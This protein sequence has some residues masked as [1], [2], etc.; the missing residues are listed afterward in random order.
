MLI[1]IRNRYTDEIL[2]ST[3]AKDLRGADLVG[4]YLRGA[5]LRDANLGGADLGGAYLRDADLRGAD[6]R[7]ANLRDADLGGADLRDAKGIDPRSVNPLLSLFL[8]PGPVRSFKLVNSFGQGPYRGGITYEVGESYEVGE[9]NNDPEKDCGAGIN[10]ATLPWCI[11]EGGEGYRI[12]IAEHTAEDIV[13]I[14]WFSDG[15]Y[16]VKRCKIV[17]EVSV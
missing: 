4:A 1:E 11:R 2:F 9:V 3:E 7:D 10:L 5:Y 6:L 8:Q 14:P 12:L 13:A 15:K 17:G 16:R